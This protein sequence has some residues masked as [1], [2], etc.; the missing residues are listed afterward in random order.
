MAHL[1]SCLA[2]TEFNNDEVRDMD[3]YRFQ[4]QGRTIHIVKYK[5]GGILHTAK[6]LGCAG[7]ATGKYKHLYNLKYIHVAGTT[8]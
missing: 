2:T 6:V 1:R 7:K 3:G 5:D 8:E 4:S